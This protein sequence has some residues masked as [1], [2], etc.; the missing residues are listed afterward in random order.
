[1]SKRLFIV[2]SRD[3]VDFSWFSDYGQIEA[4]FDNKTAANNYIKSSQRSFKNDPNKRTPMN[5]NRVWY[6]SVMDVED[7]DKDYEG[8]I[9]LLLELRLGEGIRGLDILSAC[10]PGEL[11]KKMG[12]VFEKRFWESYEKYKYLPDLAE[13]IYPDGDGWMLSSFKEKVYV[14][15]TIKTLLILKDE[16]N[17]L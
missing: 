6:M 15:T 17:S 7:L 5:P 2:A 3:D 8:E 10:K 12:S 11:E 4:V 9:A 14:Q 16:T 1:M 13:S